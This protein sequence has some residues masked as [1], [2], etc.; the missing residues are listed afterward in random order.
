MEEASALDV[1][2]N[3]RTELLLAKKNC[4]FSLQSQKH[5]ENYKKLKLL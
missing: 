5:I 3:L 1:L 2:K 4:I